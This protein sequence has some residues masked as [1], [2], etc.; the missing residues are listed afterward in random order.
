M[1]SICLHCM[2]PVALSYFHL[3]CNFQWRFAAAAGVTVL[4]GFGVGPSPVLSCPA[5]GY[6]DTHVILNRIL[7]FWKWC[8]C[9]IS[10][11]RAPGDREAKLLKVTWNVM[12]ISCKTSSLSVPYSNSVAWDALQSASEYSDRTSFV[13]KQAIERPITVQSYIV[14]YTSLFLISYRTF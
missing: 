3:F 11:H 1:S 9:P 4:P 14:L 12:R 5:L 6:K 7:R 2:A 10:F 13:H 8:S